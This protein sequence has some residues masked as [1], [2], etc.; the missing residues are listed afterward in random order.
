MYFKSVIKFLLYK[1]AKKN[2]SKWNYNKHTK[3]AWHVRIKIGFWSSK[4]HRRRK[5]I[6][7]DIIFVSKVP[8]IFNRRQTKLSL[9][10]MF[11]PVDYGRWNIHLGKELES[12]RNLGSTSENNSFWRGKGGKSF[13]KGNF[14]KWHMPLFSENSK[15]ISC[16]N[17]EEACLGS[18]PS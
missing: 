11:N 1:T 3:S 7:L 4:E 15:L 2:K 10:Y 9:Y 17:L 18:Q 12:Q 5:K 16:W 6:K 13:R 8:S 14:G